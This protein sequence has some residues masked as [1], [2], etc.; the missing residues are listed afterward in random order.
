MLKDSP[1]TPQLAESLFTV[2]Y[3]VE[4]E[5]SS[6][7]GEVEDLV[8]LLSSLAAQSLT[9]CSPSSLA[10][11]LE[12]QSWQSLGARV[13]RESHSGQAFSQGQAAADPYSDW[14]MTPLYRDKGLPLDREAILPL[15]HSCLSLL[16][17]CVSS[18][19]LPFLPRQAAATVEI[20]DL[21]VT[22]PDLEALGNGLDARTTCT[23]V[24]AAGQGLVQGL[25][26]A[27]HCMLG[28]EVLQ[29]TEA[30]LASLLLA[31]DPELMVATQ[32]G[33]GVTRSNLVSQLVARILSEP[34]ADLNLALGFIGS[35]T[36]RAA[37]LNLLAKINLGMGL[38][39]RK[40]SCLALV[41]VEHCRLHGLA[42]QRDQ[43]R[44]LYV[45]ACWGRR[46][47]EL[48]ISFKAA[49]NG[50]KA[51]RVAVLRELVKRPEVGVEALILFTRAFSIHTDEALTLYTE[52]LLNKIVPRLDERGEVVMDDFKAVTDKIDAA[53]KLITADDV[54]FEHLQKMF[55]AVC[56]YNY[57]VLQYLLSKIHYTL[58]YRDQAPP[59][60]AKAD[61]ILGFLM[62]YRRVA[63]PLPEFEVDPWM[64]DRSS[65]FP[66]AL[67]ALRLPLLSLCTFSKKEKFK[68]LE[69]EFQMSTYSAW[70]NMVGVLELGSS[71]ADNILYFTVK[72]TVAAMLEQQKER[73][74]AVDRDSWV[75]G[76]INRS[77]LEEIQACVGQINNPS[78]AAAASNW[79]LNRLP[80]GS[81]KVLA[82]VGAE[83]T[84]LGWCHK[85]GG[86]EAQEGLEHARRNRR[87]LQ[88]EQALHRHGLAS[89]NYL[90]LLQQNKPFELIN[91]LF[92]DPSVEARSLV[93][94]GQYPD[95][96][97]AAAAI[98]SINEFN[99]VK[100][101]YE[102]LDRWLPLATSPG[103]A[104][105]D[106]TLSDFSLGLDT[107]P[108]LPSSN[109]DEANL[110]RCVY[111]LQ[112]GFE[113]GR[114]YLLKYAFSTDSMVTTSHK[115]RALKCLFSICSEEELVSLTGQSLDSLRDGLRRLV[116]L[117]RLEAL[118]LPYSL[119]NLSADSVGPL[120]EGVWRSCRLSP[121]GVSLT[122]DLCA[123]FGVWTGTLWAA[124]LDQMMKF[125]ML[126]ELRSTLRLLNRQPHLWNCPQF[127]KA[128][129]MVLQAS[130]LTLLPPVTKVGFGL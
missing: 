77:V 10:D 100:M 87:Q 122:R 24:T 89:Q 85:E 50:S 73:G 90:D 119:E 110:L 6:G 79:V 84:V 4:A 49:F 76:H 16:L 42:K 8:S 48:D 17:P 30:P 38:D 72:N 52:G 86:K 29:R 67:A 115:L 113:G 109:T 34:R 13:H 78:F 69:Q 33:L 46:L 23:G 18:P 45:K 65:P 36:K 15:V 51:E 75:L 99:L 104:S 56:P 101:K 123:E 128:W 80:R 40:I 66:R 96:A 61:R 54:L 43:F 55:S 19:P 130:L 117:A 53:L 125:S 82:S 14:R 9:Y 95:I 94:A 1:V 91:A 25:Q 64:K 97:G 2:I 111:L 63:E 112:D 35:E 106:D 70:I 105:A 26:Q 68:L 124:L 41:G 3:R 103:S 81:D 107:G 118:G 32:Q 22:A 74:V 88:T 59:H 120:L 11:T 47:A 27:G 21:D 121:E 126:P 62:Q 92:E 71:G 98:A 5:L 60:L 12:L 20:Q 102:L 37:S 28:F 7:R 129:N 58:A 44:E 127:L 108:D 31:T 114:Q 83:A 57:S 116:Y 93:A 39:F